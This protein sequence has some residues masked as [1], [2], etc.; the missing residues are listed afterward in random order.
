MASITQQALCIIEEERRA[1]R[2]EEQKRIAVAEAQAVAKAQAER[3]VRVQL[4]TE[5][6]LARLA[7]ERALAEEQAVAVQAA[8][9]A[10][11][12][13]ELTR[14]RARSETE[15]LREELEAASAQINELK[16]LVHALIVKVATNCGYPA[17]PGEVLG[18]ARIEGKKCLK[19]YINRH[20]GNAPVPNLDHH[21]MM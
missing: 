2:V 19:D 7:A 21:W 13:A 4:Q 1:A 10:A 12:Q 20:Y 14:L 3:A 5:R 17:E 9:A 11:L 18:V 6:E 15:I 16:G 8:E